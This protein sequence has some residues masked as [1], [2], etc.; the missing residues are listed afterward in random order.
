MQESVL[1]A[2]LDAEP[3]GRELL[4]AFEGAPLVKLGDQAP[5]ALRQ[6]VENWRAT[7]AGANELA[8]ALCCAAEEPQ[9]HPSVLGWLLL[10]GA[11]PSVPWSLGEDDSEREPSRPLACAVSAR[12]V[13]ACA[14]LLD[15]GAQISATIAQEA[16]FSFYAYEHAE[17]HQGASRDKPEK[18]DAL[19]VAKL[20]LSRSSVEA[21]LGAPGN[22][23]APA[24]EFCACLRAS[25]LLEIALARVD[26]A[27]MAEER[28]EDSLPADWNR[29]IDALFAAAQVSK[30]DATAKTLLRGGHFD[31][32]DLGCAL[33]PALCANNV[34]VMFA[35]LENGADPAV[36]KMWLSP[37]PEVADAAP[38]SMPQPARAL[39][40]IN[41]A[42]L[43]AG[44]EAFEAWLAARDMA[45]ETQP[46]H[47]GRRQPRL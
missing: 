27:L 7:P 10:A 39:P 1:L 38:V 32:R 24:F 4:D 25:D 22:G 46:S 23:S 5:C 2:L 44:R 30:G 36:A 8:F 17:D 12:N 13:D 26:S 3:N 47:S 15:A 9:E 41:R 34:T 37:D 20:I 31:A 18:Q 45:S 19:R 14:R 11:D 6:V 16:V 40:A 28:G 35:L 21:I 42:L 43:E 33:V 29:R